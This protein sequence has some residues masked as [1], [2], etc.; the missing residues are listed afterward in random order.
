M[1][2][3]TIR[4]GILGAGGVAEA[5]H[6]PVLSQMP[7]VKVA[8]LCDQYK[9]R[10]EK[11]AREWGI[12]GAFDDLAACP[13]VD[14]VLVA[15]PVGHRRDALETVF[16]RGW[17][18]FVEKPFATTTDEH[19][20]IVQDA[21]RANVVVGVGLVRRF[22]R[23]TSI[24][25]QAL[26]R[27]LF[28]QVIEVWAAEATR[29]VTT[30]REGSWYQADRAAAGGGVLME[31]GSH[32]VD[33]VFQALGAESFDGLRAT[34]STAGDLDIEVRATANVRLTGAHESV[35]LHLVVSRMQD[36]YSGVVI[37]CEHAAIRF[38]VDAGSAVELLD[39]EDRTVCALEG[40]G[41]GTN[42]HRAFF[43]EWQAFLAQCRSRTQSLVDAASALL[44]TR[45]IEAAY[46][47]GTEMSPP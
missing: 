24:V 18:A 8:W 26:A 45:F 29:L 25:R 6:L 19:L 27:K 3:N 5:C 28:G 44:G 23:S 2:S 16:R 40:A 30:G 14:A 41:G 22:Y 12:A 4:I 9:G 38:G 36:L 47:Q 31:T 42:L 43:L 34:F 35:P 15:I 10:A 37:R 1:T 13:D 11:L 7:D 39:A 33:Q 21:A 17:H 20:R 46:T 32:T